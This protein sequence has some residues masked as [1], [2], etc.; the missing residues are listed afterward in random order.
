MRAQYHGHAL[1]RGSNETRCRVAYQH[2]GASGALIIVIMSVAPRCQ[3]ISIIKH[4]LRLVNLTKTLL[5]PDPMWQQG[6]LT[7]ALCGVANDAC[8]GAAGFPGFPAVRRKMTPLLSV[9]GSIIPGANASCSSLGA[10]TRPQAPH[11]HWVS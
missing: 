8:L 9:S 10:S 2:D 11:A 3:R 6:F 7:W 1:Y 5:S 4:M